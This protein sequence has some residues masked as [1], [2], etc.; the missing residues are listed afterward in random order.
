MRA[1][2]HL[3]REDLLVLAASLPLFALSTWWVW[4]AEVPGWSEALIA[5]CA[6]AHLSLVVR[7]TRPWITYGA[8]ALTAFVLL[9][10]PWL[11]THATGLPGPFPPVLLPSAWLFGVAVY[12]VAAHAST[13]RWVALAVGAAGVAEVVAILWNGVPWFLDPVAGLVA[14]RVSVALAG[15]ALLL[16]AYAC[17]RWR[18]LS[19]VHDDLTGR[20]SHLAGERDAA[21]LDAAVTAQ[22]TRMARE[23]HGTVAD[24]LDDIL[25]SAREGRRAAR[26]APALA[27]EALADITAQGEEALGRVHTLLGLLDDPDPEEVLAHDTRAPVLAAEHALSPQPQLEDL[28]KLIDA[29]RGEGLVVS[30]SIEGERGELPVASQL[31]LYRTAQEALTNTVRHAGPGA[32][33]TVE[34]TWESADVVIAIDDEIHQ[35]LDAAELDERFGEAVFVGEEYREGRGL[36]TVRERLE[37]VGGDLEVEQLDGGFSVRGRVPRR[38]QSAG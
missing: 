30:L 29:A 8:T 4:R 14:W 5:A 36:R 32:V 18:A 13:Y 6:V 28:P 12:S 37:A 24:L 25:T 19:R 35:S 34:I 31:A 22:Q 9:A 10:A 7:S 17:G 23:I 11:G 3:R 33:A 26:R 16:L 38:P 27:D 20:W 1:L 15:L 21:H 2:S